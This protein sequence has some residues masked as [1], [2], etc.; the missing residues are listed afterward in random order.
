MTILSSWGKWEQRAGGGRKGGGRVNRGVGQQRITKR[1]QMLSIADNK[2]IIGD[3][4]AKLWA[5]C[6]GGRRWGQ[7]GVELL[8]RTKKGGRPCAQAA[9]R[10]L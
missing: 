9:M 7:R 10:E 6:G 3:T 5:R 4:A 1:R 2:G 8:A